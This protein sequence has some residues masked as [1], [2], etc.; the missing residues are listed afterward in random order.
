MIDIFRFGV[1][2]SEMG[3]KFYT[4]RGVMK[5]LRELAKRGE[6]KNASIALKW[7]DVMGVKVLESEK[8]RTD[9]MIIDAAGKE[10]AVATSDRELRARL[11]RA[12]VKTIYIRARK[13]LE[14]G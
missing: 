11:K 6:K 5:E 9:D 4:V 2:V 7:I 1:D 13:H 3:D 10:Y 12:G 8:R 14:L